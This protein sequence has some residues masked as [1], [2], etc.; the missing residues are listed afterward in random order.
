MYIVTS[1]EF[2]IIK[3][4]Q[5]QHSE[6]PLEEISVQSHRKEMFQSRFKHHVGIKKDAVTLALAG[7]YHTLGFEDALYPLM[8]DHLSLRETQQEHSHDYLIEAF[9]LTPPRYALAARC[10]GQSAEV[11]VI[12]TVDFLRQI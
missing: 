2:E 7:K 5:H 1:G 3:G 11:I 8:K 4:V 12:N 6:K 9:N 10:L